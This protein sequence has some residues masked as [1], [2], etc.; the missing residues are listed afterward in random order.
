M[1]AR[2]EYLIEDLQV[3]IAT[4]NRESLDFLEEIFPKHS[5]CNFEIII[6][7]QT[8]KNV[9]IKSDVQNITVINTFERGLSKSRNTALEQVTKEICLILDDDVVLIEG[10]EKH[11]INAYNQI[12][13][14]DCITF[15]TLT[16]LGEP[17]WKYPKTKQPFNAYILKNVLSPEITFK[18]QIIRKL[19]LKFDEKFGLGAIFEDGENY[20]FLKKV[21]KKGR[22][23]YFYPKYISIHEPYSSSDE[24]ASDRLIYARSALYYKLYKTGAYI[25][26]IKYI[27]FIVRK[28]F[29]N[30]DDAFSKFKKGIAGINKYKEFEN[31]PNYK[32]ENFNKGV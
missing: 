28:R 12:E 3:L 6:V 10:F 29:I 20:I 1:E 21:L 7:N 19:N 17:Y 14:A 27:F 16:T 2:K 25:W 32:S 4:T 23:P 30:I 11:I 9:L 31:T 24:I 15:Q 26:L 13:Q 8:S 5:Y 22:K 18:T